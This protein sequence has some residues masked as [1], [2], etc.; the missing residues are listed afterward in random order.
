[1]STANRR[2][3]APH[4]A[5]N[6]PLIRMNW[7]RNKSGARKLTSFRLTHRRGN[8]RFTIRR[9]AC[10]IQGGLAKH[11]YRSIGHERHRDRLGMRFGAFQAVKKNCDAPGSVAHANKASPLLMESKAESFC[12]VVR[13]KQDFAETPTDRRRHPG[14]AKSEPESQIGN[15]L[16]RYDPG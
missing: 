3:G 16:I 13:T 1:M 10:A 15:A 11:V 4:F 7:T 8:K 14:E 2:R 6:G 9:T 5:T 12:F